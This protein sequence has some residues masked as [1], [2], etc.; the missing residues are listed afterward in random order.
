MKTN[1]I[2]PEYVTQFPANFEDG[3]L[4]ISEEFETAG[5]LCCCG[6]GERVI[7]PLSPAKWQIRKS[8]NRVSLSPSVGNWKYA[9]QSHYWISFN[10]VIEDKKFDSNS[11]QIV[12][13]RDRR[14]MDRYIERTNA[15]AETVRV[16][17]PSFVG[18]LL[19]WLAKLLGS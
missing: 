13:H 8:G 11:I 12:Q 9:C 3:V 7:T 1:V 14:D 17:K 5:H 15:A 2:R 10:E 18:K 6:C 4:Y 16:P 19:N